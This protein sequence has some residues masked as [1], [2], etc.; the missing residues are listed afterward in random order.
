MRPYDGENINACSNNEGNNDEFSPDTPT[1]D[2]NINYN[3]GDEINDY[4][5]SPDTPKNGVNNETIDN[6][7]EK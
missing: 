4:E 6:D 1:N 5:V 2:I 7:D 3:Y